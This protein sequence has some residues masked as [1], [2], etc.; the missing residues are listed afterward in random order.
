M[1][2]LMFEWKCMKNKKIIADNNNINIELDIPNFQYKLTCKSKKIINEFYT[3][4]EKN[5]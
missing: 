4:F 3:S 5:L 2:V 1:K